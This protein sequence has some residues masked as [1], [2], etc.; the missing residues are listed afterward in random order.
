MGILS[1][2]A[3]EFLGSGGQ[4]SGFSLN[5]GGSRVITIRNDSVS[6]L[7]NSGLRHTF[8]THIPTQT[9]TDGNEVPGLGFNHGNYSFVLPY[10]FWPRAAQA[11][12]RVLNIGIWDLL[13][14][15]RP[16]F[17]F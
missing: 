16:G 15:W 8:F 4:D 9:H 10:L 3:S 7:E 11:L 12:G 13:E 5:A 2:L 6:Q 17:G 14:I 1:V